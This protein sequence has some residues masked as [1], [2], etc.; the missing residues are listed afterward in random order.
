MLEHLRKLAALILT[1]IAER[2]LHR[3]VNRVR[4]RVLQHMT[5]RRVR[6]LGGVP[7]RRIARR[8]PLDKIASR[9]RVAARLTAAKESFK[10]A[11]H[12]FP[13]RV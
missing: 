12:M 1:K 11:F 8:H 2:L 3:A 13:L 9:G 6:F 7:L 10:R 4:R 5:G